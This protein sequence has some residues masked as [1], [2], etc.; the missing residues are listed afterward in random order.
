MKYLLI[1]FVLLLFTSQ[2]FSQKGKSDL[3]N[4]MFVVC[5]NNIALPEIA[6]YAGYNDSLIATFDIINYKPVNIKIRCA[7]PSG[8]ADG[9]YSKCTIENIKNLNFLEDSLGYSLFVR[10]HFS[11]NFYPNYADYSRQDTLDFYIRQKVNPT[12][13][14][15]FYITVDKKNKSVTCSEVIYSEKRIKFAEDILVERVFSGDSDTSIIIKNNCP[16]F[17]K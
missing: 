8:C 17:S 2:C 7:K 11:P 9:L 16:Y 10:Y 4:K 6:Y 15:A 5:N 14:P 12:I 3:S 1:T 13:D